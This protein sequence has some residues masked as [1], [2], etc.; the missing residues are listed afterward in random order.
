[1]ESERKNKGQKE[2]EERRGSVVFLNYPPKKHLV[3][4]Q[5]PFLRE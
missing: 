1:M 2:R 4:F 5:L 3:I